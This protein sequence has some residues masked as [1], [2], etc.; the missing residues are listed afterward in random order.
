MYPPLKANV[1]IM[2]IVFGI[3]LYRSEKNISRVFTQHNK[4]I[5]YIGKQA[6]FVNVLLSTLGYKQFCLCFM[7][8]K[9]VD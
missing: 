6:I 2:F 1:K 7:L 9:M 8:N 4:H 5:I 3:I